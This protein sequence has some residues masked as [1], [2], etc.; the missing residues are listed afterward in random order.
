VF[1]IL[2]LLGYMREQLTVHPLGG[3]IM[4]SDGTGRCGAV[5]HMG[6]LFTGQGSEIHKGIVCVD[7]AVI[8]TSLGIN[9]FATI[10]ALAERTCD[11]LIKEKEWTV[12]E[13]ENGTLDLFGPPRVEHAMLSYLQDYDG[14][15]A[16][17][18][19]V[20]FTEIMDGYIHI[21]DNISDFE[22]AHDVAKG[23]SSAASFCLTVDIF[24]VE[25]LTTPSD[26]ASIATGAFS[27]GALSPHPLMIR[28][29]RVQF[30]TVDDEVSDGT[31]LVY[32][33]TLLSTKG[34]MYLLNGYK[35]VNSS[36]AFSASQTWKATTTLYTTI[37]RLDGS[38]VG[39]GIL[40]ISWRN[41][42]DE[43]ESFGPTGTK[44]SLR[45]FAGPLKFIN[46]FVQNV[47]K[48][49]FRPLQPL[50]F[51]DTLNSG[52][53]SKPAPTIAVDLI[54]EDGVKTNIRLWEPIDGVKRRNMAILFIP[55]ASVDH[56][57]FALPTIQTNTVDYFTALGYRCYIPTL[58]FGILPV[59]EQGYT[60]YDARLDVK[61]AMEFVREQEQNRKFYVVCHC[62]GSVATGIALLTGTVQADW[63]SGMTCSQ[64]FTNFR[65][66]HINQL[67]ASTQ[68]L[69]KIYTVRIQASHSYPSH[70][71]ANSRL[72]QGPC[73]SVVPILHCPHLTPDSTPARHTAALLPRRCRGRDVHVDR[74][75]PVLSHL[76]APVD[77]RETQSRDTRAPSKVLWRNTYV[78]SLTSHTHGRNGAVPFA[79]QRTAA[80]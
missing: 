33:L 24:R 52:Y 77:A 27:C 18:T 26:S 70:H 49:L 56:Q 4:S 44:N 20:R 42:V 19:G 55:G 6:R 47:A 58:R 15:S 40:H 72:H 69:L 73:R 78:F 46:F 74:V 23:S 61:A 22:V 5:D 66:G 25:D 7:A 37:T 34:E 17:R 10:T 63:I 51:P 30:F 12:D 8:P 59:A 43:I 11:M 53:L 16:D 29:G 60:A 2:T 31:N 62:I 65:F 54:A 13:T 3:T 41:F 28:D 48:Y 38:L 1:G 32:K 57:I 36:M 9:P 50:Q 79:R 67:K 21:G 14:N 35:V 39:R 45:K 80:S 64:V 75:S 76:R 71:A 68:A